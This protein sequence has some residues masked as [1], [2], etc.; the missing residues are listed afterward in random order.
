VLLACRD[1]REDIFDWDAFVKRMIGCED[2]ATAR[3]ANR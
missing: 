3:R 1:E 2:I